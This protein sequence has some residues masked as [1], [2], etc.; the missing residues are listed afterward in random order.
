MTR[1]QLTDEQRKL[2]EPFQPIGE[3][4]PY[5]ERLREQFEGA[6]WRFRTG[7]Q[8]R[9]MPEAFGPWPTV[10]GRSAGRPAPHPAGRGRRG[11]AYSSRANRAHPR[12]RRIKAVIPEKNDQAANARRRAARAAVRSLSTPSSTVTA[13]PAS[14]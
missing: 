1:R 11:K 14:G 10:Y 13:T 3:Y 6:I 2:I 12:R 7:A 5:P 4:G 8:W 9:E